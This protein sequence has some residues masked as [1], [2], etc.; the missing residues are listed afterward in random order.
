[1]GHQQGMG[2]HDVLLRTACVLLVYCLFQVDLYD[3][4]GRVLPPHLDTY[5][6]ANR[7]TMFA[8]QDHMSASLQYKCS[9]VR[10][11]AMAVGRS[12]SALF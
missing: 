11:A 3:R 1:M 12:V 2:A 9:T 4:L 8:V 6:L 10:A 7:Y 5:F